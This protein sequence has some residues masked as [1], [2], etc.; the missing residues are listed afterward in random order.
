M[1]RLVFLDVDGT[2]VGEGGV[3]PCAWAAVERAKAQGLRLSLVTGRP[4]AGE[5]L[6][7]A[8]RLDPEG[9]H[10]FESGAVV[11]D[12][13]EG[14]P[15]LVE[16]LPEEAREAIRLGRALGLVLEGYG[17]DG[18][19]YREGD[20]PL[21]RAHEALLGL[22][23]REA[24]L[25]NPPSP[26]VR[27][28]VLVGPEDP[29]EAFLQGLPPGLEAHLAQSPRMPHVTF[30]SLTRKG[31]GKRAAAER[32]AQAYGL[33]LEEAAMVGDGE[34]DLEL[35]Q[36]VGMGIAM[37]NAPEGVKRAAKRVVA[38]VEACGL[39]EALLGLL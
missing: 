14:R 36:A 4:G 3:P 5:A 19:Y 16:A 38:P 28:Q 37:G 6:A 23:S 9:L 33:G 7:Y 35:I 34:N 39:A 18:G 24:D 10:V 31:V 15:L 29:L 32:V 20:H 13:K 11:L 17:A 27:L 8:R 1:I 26:L 12:L 2:L 22:P 25:L 21:I 30:L